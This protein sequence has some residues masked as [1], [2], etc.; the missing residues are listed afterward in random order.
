MTG[1]QPFSR[2]FLRGG[3]EADWPWFKEHF[4]DAPRQIVDFLAA[5]GISLEGRHV[6]DVGCGDGIMALGLKELARPAKV[7]GFDL[8]PVD[9]VR[10]LEEAQASKAVEVL[11]SGLEF[12]TALPNTLPADTHEFD[13]IVSWSV[14]EHAFTPVSF[15]KEMRRILKPDG[16]LFLQV[17]PFYRSQ[18]GSH[19]WR[20]FPEGF[21]HLT[22]PEDEIV[23]AVRADPKGSPEDA[24]LAVR[25]FRALNQMTVEELQRVL[26]AAGLFVT[27]YELITGATHITHELAR[28]SLLELGVSGIKL[29]AVVA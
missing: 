23:A 13:V 8:E 22:R 11:P 20:W 25:E 12:R 1:E 4:E 14:F 18:H 27:K 10:L 17:W 24:E 16:L 29:M 6:A 19:L 28:Y 3:D 9:T 15:I 7:V 2:R 5:D 21:A 26:L